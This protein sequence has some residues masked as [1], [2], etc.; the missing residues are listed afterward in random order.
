M[1]FL[2]L[3]VSLLAVGDTHDHCI[4]QT[5]SITPRCPRVKDHS[6][7]CNCVSSESVD[8]DFLACPSS[9]P[10]IGRLHFE[11]CDY[12]THMYIPIGVD[13][14]DLSMKLLNCNAE[15]SD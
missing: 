5:E 3:L 10:F 9:H 8:V 14:M 15:G 4:V 11:R 13:C 1:L 12:D 2:A 7:I 6:K